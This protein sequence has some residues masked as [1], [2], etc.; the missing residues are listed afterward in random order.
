MTHTLVMEWAKY[1]VNSVSPGLV[2]TVMMYW[3]PQQPDWEQQLK[4]HGGF[5]QGWQRCRSWRVHMFIE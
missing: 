4:Y 5:P 1:G 2:K 3:M